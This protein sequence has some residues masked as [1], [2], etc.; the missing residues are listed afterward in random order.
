MRRT[1]VARIALALLLCVSTAHG[2]AAD[3]YPRQPGVDALHYVFRLTI[4]DLNNEIAGES[5]VTRP[6]RHRRRR[7]RSRS[8]W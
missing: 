6:L 8:T 1:F 4:S 3:T 7:Q 5:T 2:L